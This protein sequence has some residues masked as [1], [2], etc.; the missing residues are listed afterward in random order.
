MQTNVLPGTIGK[1]VALSACPL[2]FFLFLR[3][4]VGEKFDKQGWNEGIEDGYG[5]PP[6]ARKE[7][8]H[9]LTANHRLKG[10]KIGQLIDLLGEPDNH[11]SAE[12]SYD[13]IFE[14]DWIDPSYIKSLDFRY[15]VDSTIDTFYVTEWNR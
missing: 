4:C 13:I 14:W 9:D 2:I 12:V 7:M 1:I 5:H 15:S 11:D 10:L 6:S 3:S 8:L